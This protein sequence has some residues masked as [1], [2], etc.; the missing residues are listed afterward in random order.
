MP[1]HPRRSSYWAGGLSIVIM[2]SIVGLR[3]IGDRLYD[4]PPNPPLANITSKPLVVCLAGGKGRIEAAFD[5]FAS[6]TGSELF[7]I[8]AGP[9]VTL[10]QI[11]KNVDPAVVAKLSNLQIGAIR[12]ERESA[13]T[14]ENAY[15]LEKF[16]DNHPYINDVVVVT[17]RYHMRRSLYVLQTLL[18]QKVNL[19]P[20][21][22]PEEAIERLNWWQSKVGIQVTME[23]YGK[24]LAARILIPKIGFF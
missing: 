14:I 7:I 10:T 8:G 21:T 22:P 17:S 19:I 13:N 11:L 15:V 1:S 3:T 12:I 18:K 6:G 16:L 24:Y 5:L 4:F 23:E 9:K 2:L 20:Y